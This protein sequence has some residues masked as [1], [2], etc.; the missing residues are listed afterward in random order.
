MN[1]K[2]KLLSYIFF[3]SLKQEKNVK[4]KVLDMRKRNL[5]N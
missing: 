3:C 5:K 1:K 4:K 2:A